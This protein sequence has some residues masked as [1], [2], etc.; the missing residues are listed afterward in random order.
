MPFATCR[1]KVAPLVSYPVRQAERISVKSACTY[2]DALL[3]HLDCQVAVPLART[4]QLHDA[5][6]G[7]PA[8]NDFHIDRGVL[9]VSVGIGLSIERDSKQL[10]GPKIYWN[11]RGKQTTLNDSAFGGTDCHSPASC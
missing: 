3:S 1:C 4:R 7:V 10:P 2:C 9:D 8:K 11:C 6:A 5:G